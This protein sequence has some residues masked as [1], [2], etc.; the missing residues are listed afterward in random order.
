MKFSNLIADRFK[1][2]LLL[3][4]MAAVIGITVYGFLWSL[5]SRERSKE[6]ILSHLKEVIVAEVQSQNAFNI[7][8]EL[9]RIVNTWAKT[10]EFPLRVDVYIDEKHWAHGGPMKPFGVFSTNDSH[11]EVLATGQKLDLDISMNLTG[12][13]LRLL[14]V[15]VIFIGFFV[16]VYLSLKKGLTI[17][18]EEI[19][20]PLEE[21]VIRLGV[22][23]QNLSSHAKK[24]FLSTATQVN[25]LKNLD[26]SLG[27]LFNRINSLEA[28]VA[29][30]KYS[31]GQL[32]MAKQVTHA[33]NGSLSALSLYVDQAKP[34]DSIDKK[35]LKSIINQITSISSDLTTS[36]DKDKDSNLNSTFDLKKSIKNVID[37]K[38]EEIL[39]LKDKKI[40][41]DFDVPEISLVLSGSKAKFELAL[42]NLITNSIESITEVGTIHVSAE[43]IQGQVI[44]KVSDDGCGIAAE[45]LPHLMKEG[46]T[47]GKKN[48]NGLGLF[49]VKSIVE[50]FSGSISVSSI[51]GTTIKINLPL[52]EKNNQ[53]DIV[54]FPNQQ[55]V[56]VDDEECIHHAWDILFKNISGKIQ[57]IHLYSGVEFETWITK[58]SHDAFQSRLFLFDY[59]LKGHMNGLELIEKH[60][61]MF[62]C[63]LV[64]GM[65]ED[66]HVIKESNRLK[67]KTISKDEL[68][69]LKI[70]MEENVVWSTRHGLLEVT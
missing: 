24:G 47:F 4:F 19:S 5:H 66:D 2:I 69:R 15:L 39:K 33:L 58:N 59:D 70:K 27:T 35:F 6:F 46:A 63:F 40:Q 62:E 38:K 36:V 50:E 61:L 9:N 14:G 1:K 45:I 10:Q 31:E 21:R 17:V 3:S 67:V 49:H 48:G 26:E 18:V 20:K 43:K 51:K 23:S 30:K 53:E 13:L 28:E 7:D 65:A 12:P 37:Q 16:A 25:E 57:V 32:Q 41:I 44:I 22:A 54:L 11:S 64:T 29:E 42:V 34:Q 60:Q 68:S 55:L 8:G 52:V 56:I